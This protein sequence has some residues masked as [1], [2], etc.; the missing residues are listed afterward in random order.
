V[1]VKNGAVVTM[2]CVRGDSTVVIS[3]QGVDERSRF[4]SYG[5]V[6]IHADTIST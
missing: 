1:S 3:H 5:L 2:S 6:Y 4:C